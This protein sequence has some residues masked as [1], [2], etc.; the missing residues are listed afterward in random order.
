MLVDDVEE[1]L[2]TGSESGLLGPITQGKAPRLLII[3][4]ADYIIQWDQSYTHMKP[5]SR[6]TSL[7][8]MS[9]LEVVHTS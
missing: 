2:E 5:W 3:G 1:R 4:G 6:R 7:S 9:L 8:S